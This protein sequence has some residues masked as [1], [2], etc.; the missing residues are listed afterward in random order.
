MNVKMGKLMEGPGSI[1]IATAL[2]RLNS[3]FDPEVLKLRQTPSNGVLI[4]RALHLLLDDLIAKQAY[5]AEHRA[6][7][8]RETSLPDDARNIRNMQNLFDGV[9]LACCPT[10]PLSNR[11]HGYLHHWLQKR[12]RWYAVKKY[13]GNLESGARHPISNDWLY[14]SIPFLLSKVEIQLQALNDFVEKNK[15]ISNDAQ[16]PDSVQPRRYMWY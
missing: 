16:F 15:D 3:S 7:V 1:G 13:D 5:L 2:S 12:A 8:I 4:E 6:R 11:I 10:S 9:A 14:E